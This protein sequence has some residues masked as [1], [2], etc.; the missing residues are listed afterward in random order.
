MARHPSP[1]LA[2]SPQRSIG[3]VSLPSRDRRCTHH[4]MTAPVVP[5]RPRPTRRPSFPIQA[6][7]IRME[8]TTRDLTARTGICL[9]NSHRTLLQMGHRGLLSR[10]TSHRMVY[11]HQ[12]RSQVSRE[13]PIIRPSP[14]RLTLARQISPPSASHLPTFNPPHIR[15][16]PLKSMVP[17]TAHSTT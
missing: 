7:R 4:T 15:Q 5:I 11:C 9:A 2:P 17:T 12:H 3:L 14:Q 1:L 16:S 6:D 13:T 8:P 10:R